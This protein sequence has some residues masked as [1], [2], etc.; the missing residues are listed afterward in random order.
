MDTRARLV[1]GRSLSYGQGITFWP[2]LEVVRRLAGIAD[3]ATPPES[4]ARLRELVEGA[5]SV[6]GHPVGVGPG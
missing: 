5:Q 4:T 1:T 6:E 3:D 2:V